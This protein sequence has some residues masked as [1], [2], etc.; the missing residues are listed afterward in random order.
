M[1]KQTLTFSARIEIRGLTKRF[2]YHAILDHLSLTINEGDF[3]VLIGAN[4]AGKTTLLRILA[5]LI[6]PTEGEII[7]GSGQITN[8]PNLRRHIGYVGHQSMFYQDL[9]A[10]ENLMHYARLYRLSEV[11]KAITNGLNTSGLDQYR[12]QPVRTF[13]RGMQQRLSLARAMLH[14]P[15]IMLFDEPYTGLDQEAAQFLDKKLKALNQPNR[16]IL[17]AAH[18]P[19]RLL[20][21]ASHIAWLKAGKIVEHLPISQLHKSPALKRY[22]GA[23]A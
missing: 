21:M 20:P 23:P 17:M 11:D 18:R 10:A 15:E 16:T 19:H 13:S 12:N 4:G 1:A 6:H 22:L 3:C 9:T 8:G 7:F 5:G 14:E 2:H